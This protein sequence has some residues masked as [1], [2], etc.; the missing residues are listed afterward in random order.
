M[1]LYQISLLSMMITAF[2][3]HAT[4]VD[5]EVSQPYTNSHLSSGSAAVVN[6]GNILVVGDDMEWL[7]SV[8]KD[9]QILDRYS[10]STSETPSEGRM[11]KKLKLDFESMTKL[12]YQSQEYYLILGSGSKKVK[13]EHA[14][15]MAAGD[16]SKQILSLSPL[17]KALYKAS[18]MT[19]KQKLNIEGLANSDDMAYI[20]NRGNEGKNIVFSLKLDQMMNFISGKSDSL[21][22]LSAVDIELP[23]IGAF[24]ATLSG[25]DFWPETNSI[26]YS[27]SVEGTDTAVG[28]GKVMGSFIGV[29]PIDKLT[30]SA[31]VLDLTKNTQL[32]TLNG[33][34]VLTKVESV[35]IANSNLNEVQGYLVSD[36]DNGT[37]QFFSF[38][39][40]AD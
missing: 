37:S 12:T 9:Y 4:G 8:N 39:M 25:A 35:A 21:T 26:V 17:Y 34:N 36:N 15:L 28:D 31:G 38:K 6:D 23:S 16:H 7:F 14:V 19:G 40:K 3:A 2:G 20:F 30:N 27:A 11:K 5:L 24:Q 29:L 18:G 1:K 33:Q 13:R 32:L 10:L 22:S